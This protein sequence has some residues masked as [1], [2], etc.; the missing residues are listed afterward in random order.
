VE[1]VRVTS[2]ADLA[3]DAPEATVE[4]EAENGGSTTNEAEEAKK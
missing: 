1:E 2:E 3:N 4:V